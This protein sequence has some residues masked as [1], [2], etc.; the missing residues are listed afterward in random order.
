MPRRPRLMDPG[1]IYHLVIRGNNR[2]AIFTSDRERREYL[3]LLLDATQ[4]FKCIW[5]AYALMTNHAH[6]LGCAASDA[7]LS[8]VMQSVTGAY[9][10]RFNRRHGRVGHVFQGRFYSSRIHSDSYLLEAVR[11]IHLNPVRAGMVKEPSAY[12][13]SS[14][15]LYLSQYAA[16]MDFINTSLVLGHFRN[17]DPCD[18]RGGCSRFHEFVLEGLR[19]PVAV[20][21]LWRPI[22]LL[23]SFPQGSVPQGEDR[24]HLK[25]HVGY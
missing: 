8:T 15:R 6:L 17:A 22:E 11:Y 20:A 24:V 9:A 5:Y 23:N 16:S 1:S 3:S 14:H 4:R 25:E 12:P 13:W 2:E 18:E 19:H 7:S 10:Q 21:D